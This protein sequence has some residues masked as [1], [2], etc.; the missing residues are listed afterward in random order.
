MSLQEN[1]IRE[2]KIPFGLGILF[3]HIEFPTE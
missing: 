1:K 3:C 2:D